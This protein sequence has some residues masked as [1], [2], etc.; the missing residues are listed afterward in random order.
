MGLQMYGTKF[1]KFFINRI[2]TKK[3]NNKFLKKLM[4]NKNIL[5]IMP[6]K[7]D[8]VSPICTDKAK[9]LNSFEVGKKQINKMP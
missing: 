7:K 1:A 6:D 8:Q 9:L 3:K 2:K 5:I 4:H